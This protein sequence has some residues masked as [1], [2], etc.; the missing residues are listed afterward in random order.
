MERKDRTS[1]VRK[2]LRENFGITAYKQ[3]VQKMNRE[4]A[5]VEMQKF[6]IR[7][8]MRDKVSE[9]SLDQLFQPINDRFGVKANLG[10]H[11]F[12]KI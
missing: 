3:P 2:I 1:A 5:V 8:K 4:E 12:G 11:S 10:I 6:L 9:L 7:L